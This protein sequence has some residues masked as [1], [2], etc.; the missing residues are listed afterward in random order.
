MT[1]HVH[2]KKKKSF[3]NAIMVQYENTIT[4]ME[5]VLTRSE[6]IDQ[7]LKEHGEKSFRK[8][9][10][11]HAMYQEKTLDYDEIKT[12]PLPLRNQLKS[13]LGDILTIIQKKQTEGNQAT[14]ILFETRNGAE[15]ESVMMTF[16]PN[17]SDQHESICISSQSG[18]NL[19][20]RFC[21]TGTMGLKKQLTPDEI[22]D[23]VL[24]F[25]KLYNFKGSISFMGMGEPFMNLENV[26][27]AIKILTDPELFGISERKIN[28]STVGI[29]PGIIRLMNEF[30]QV[31][32]A[33]SLHFPF[34]D[35]RSQYMPVNKLYS[36]QKVMDTLDV[37]IKTTN[38]RVFL[39]YL[40]LKDIND[41]IDH[42]QGLVN[43]I[44]SRGELQYLY[45]V[46]IINFHPG[47][48]NIPFQQ[49]NKD[50]FRKFTDYL[51]THHIKY[52]TRQ[53]FGIEIGAACGQLCVKNKI[54]NNK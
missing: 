52:S 9:Q 31:N 16:N 51:T 2:S 37:Y 26:L 45:H 30:P 24:Y 18:C 42:A 4:P 39:A 12:I 44:K 14:K 41:S 46:N 8:K 6:Q 25:R 47:D 11:L 22:T 50:T 48:P 10:I 7:I 5:Q 40:I 35:L 27:S 38:R 34:D 53:S 28:V 13:T 1:S 17:T 36:F 15:I 54:N 21:S 32:L 20:C 49:T 3:K 23:Q 19:G 29:I 43:L 33:Y